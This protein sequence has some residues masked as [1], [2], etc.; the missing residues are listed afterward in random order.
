ME[1]WEADSTTDELG[2]TEWPQ[3]DATIS[4]QRFYNTTWCDP[5]NKRQ[6]QKCDGLT[7]VQAVAG[8]Q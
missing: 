4:I 1:R 7:V 2:I 3:N 5:E 8:F 6:L